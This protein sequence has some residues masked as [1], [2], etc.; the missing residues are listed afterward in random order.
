MGTNPIAEYVLNE[1]KTLLVLGHIEIRRDD[2][3]PAQHVSGWFDIEQLS[4]APVWIQFIAHAMA[5]MVGHRAR[6]K[7]KTVVLTNNNYQAGVFGA[8]LAA[9]LSEN[10]KYVGIETTQMRVS[11][12]KER[13]HV[14]LNH[15]GYMKAERIVIADVASFTM[16]TLQ[17]LLRHVRDDRLGTKQPEIVVAC[18]LRLC[19]A[20]IDPSTSALTGATVCMGYEHIIHQ[21]VKLNRCTQCVEKSPVTHV[22]DPK[23]GF[24]VY[25]AKKEKA[26]KDA[27][28]KAVEA[29]EK[30]DIAYHAAFA[31]GQHPPPPMASVAPILKP[32]VVDP[33]VVKQLEAADRAFQAI[34]IEQRTPALVPKG[35][36]SKL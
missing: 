10:D 11:T 31:A 29:Q 35:R 9:K 20:G 6:R 3:S 16:G 25:N 4:R 24:R 27:Q 14:T 21:F 23:N 7:L 19:R 18:G 22:Y 17:Q 5:E 15:D 33:A 28:K 13:H 12:G 34:P 32:H 1:I 2:G 30:K 36:I 26:E 8:M